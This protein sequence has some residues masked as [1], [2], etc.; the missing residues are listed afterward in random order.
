VAGGGLTAETPKALAVKRVPDKAPQQVSFKR[1][2]PK[3][4]N[5]NRNFGWTAA[6]KLGIEGDK[7][8]VRQTLQVKKAWLGHW[9]SFDAKADKL[10]QSWGYVKKDGTEWKYWEDAG[11]AW[12]KLPRNV[13]SYTLNEL[14]FVKSG[15]KFVGVDDASSTWPEGFSEPG[16]YEQKKKDWL[17]NIHEVWDGK[18]KLQRKECPGSQ[19]GCCEW[20][21]DIK[22]NW[23]EN[24]GDKLVYA[25]WAADSGRSD[26]SHWFLGD[27]DAGMAGHECGH[28]LGA[29]D[30]YKETSTTYGAV[31][32]ATKLV[33]D[34]S[35]M[36][37]NLTVAY[38]RH[39]DGL[40]DQ[41][42]KK[43]NSAA[44]RSWD[45]EI[46]KV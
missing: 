39:L 2:S 26:A 23:S 24:P 30:E 19:P 6:F 7:L 10:K 35:I 22:V 38:P 41:A 1:S 28:L 32:P 9:T 12:K 11:K 36:G 13:S 8:L 45:Y 3:S 42:K 44:G 34:D 27:P 5:G 29:Y 40:R 25:V 16:N 46:K 17:K 33:E 43:V 15:S 20:S 14:Y 18:F 4:V 37:R 31:D 21:I